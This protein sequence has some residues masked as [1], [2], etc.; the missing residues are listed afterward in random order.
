MA[1]FLAWSDAFSVGVA[2]F[3]EEHK[4]LIALINELHDS[5]RAGTTG[6]SLGRIFDALIEHA[7]VHFAHEERFF[8]E[9]GFPRAALHKAMHEHLTKRLLGFRNEVGRK[10]SALLAEELLQFLGMALTH[11]IQGE[12][13]KYGA[14]L[15]T[16]GIG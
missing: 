4:Q 7:G 1:A 16:K 12:D 11:H 2:Q 8:D 10:D 9:V 13:K 6:E 5:A 15:N 14:Y 3:D